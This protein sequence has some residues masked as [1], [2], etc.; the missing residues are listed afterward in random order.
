MLLYMYNARFIRK[1]CFTIQGYLQNAVH[2]IHNK[3]D[4]R[5]SSL[6]TPG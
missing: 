1:I 5:Q 3:H 4:L 6:C 2:A